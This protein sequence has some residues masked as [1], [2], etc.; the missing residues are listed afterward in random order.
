MTESFGG[1]E[2]L[3]AEADETRR[4]VHRESGYSIA[5]PGHPRAAASANERPKYDVLLTLADAPIELGF[6]LD[7]GTEQLDKQAL[8]GAL[9]L[10]YATG[11]TANPNI[12][13]LRGPAVPSGPVAGAR[14]T[15]ALRDSDGRD[16]ES[17]AVLVRDG[18]GGLWSLYQT[19]RFRTG[20]VTPVEWANFRTALCA[21]HTWDGSTPAGQP[22]IWPTSAFLEPSV[23]IK[24][25]DTAWKEAEAKA[26]EMGP[27]EDEETG[28]LAQR[29]FSLASNDAT[30][31]TAVPRPILELT[32]RDISMAAPPR[33]AETLLRNLDDVKTFHDYRGWCWQCAWAIGNRADRAPHQRS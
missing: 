7:R 3:G 20:D 27:L 2:L 32:S 4:L 23:R 12:A 15:Y 8:A 29:L 24:F 26:A 28:L 17:L 25:V 5:V 9:A 16:M 21:E 13:A 10:T 1:F 19:I 30:P 22:A 31:S 6:R 18:A 14:G 33:A 11:R